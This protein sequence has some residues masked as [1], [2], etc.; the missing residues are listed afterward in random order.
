MEQERTEVLIPSKPSAATTA[1]PVCITQNENDP[2]ETKKA[3][4]HYRTV[5]IPD[6]LRR[7]HILVGEINAKW[8]WMYDERDRR[9]ERDEKQEKDLK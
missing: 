9:I 3:A 5:C 8:D 2:E 7:W 1:A 4:T 6:F